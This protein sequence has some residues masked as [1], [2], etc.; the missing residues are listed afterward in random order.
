LTG[1]LRRG[2]TDLTPLTRTR[3]AAEATAWRRPWPSC[4]A[5]SAAADAE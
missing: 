3:D 1:R 4:A 5:R 2:Q